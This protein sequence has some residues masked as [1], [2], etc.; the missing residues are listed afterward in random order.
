MPD[1]KQERGLRQ[2][3]LIILKI[4]P[5]LALLEMRHHH[6]LQLRRRLR[7]DLPILRQQNVG[8]VP[9]NDAGHNHG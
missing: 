1:V 6:P 9:D 2:R 5:S 4:S 3:L 7:L 8:E